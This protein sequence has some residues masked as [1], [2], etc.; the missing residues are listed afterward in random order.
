MIGLCLTSVYQVQNQVG[1][2]KAAIRRSVWDQNLTQD[3]EALR[4]EDALQRREVDDEQLPHDGGQDGVAERPVAAQAH[5]M[6]HAGLRTQFIHQNVR[7]RGS[8][9]LNSGSDTGS[10]S[11]LRA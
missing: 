6:D 2:T 3:A 10:G 1:G 8:G 7:N 5:L 11:H 9:V 4:L